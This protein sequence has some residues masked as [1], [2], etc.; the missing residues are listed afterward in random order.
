MPS[1]LSSPSIHPATLSRKYRSWV[2]HI[3]VPLYCL[4]VVSSHCTDSASRWFVG[5]SS[6]N[7]SGCCKSKRHKA[8]LLRSPPERTLTLASLS[9]HR[10]AS[11][12]RSSLCSILKLLSISVPVLIGFLS[13]LGLVGGIGTLIDN[14]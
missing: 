2:I 8:T 11:I 5:S 7:I 13:T 1:P 10:S 9:G 12:A 6:S 14:N 3:T 4:R